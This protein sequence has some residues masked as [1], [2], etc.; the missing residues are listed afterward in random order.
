MPSSPADPGSSSP[1]LLEPQPAD[2]VLAA[3][4]RAYD[5]ALQ[6]AAGGDLDGCAALLVAADAL[7]AAPLQPTPAAATLAA[8]QT[9][10]QAAHARLAAVLT[11]LRDETAAGLARTRRGR[12][13]LAGYAGLRPLGD[14]FESR[15]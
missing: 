9:E 8:L 13:A 7:L 5:E 12:Q 2:A 6:A 11:E 10:A 4:A 3:L 14:K 1:P 15:I